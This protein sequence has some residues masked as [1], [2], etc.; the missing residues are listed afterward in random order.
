MIIC[1]EPIERGTKKIVKAHVCK[2]LGF[3][4]GITA[5]VYAGKEEG[6]TLLITSLLHG[7]EWFSVLIIREFLNRLDLDKLKG[8]VI[9]I[10]VANTSAFYTGTRCIMDNSDEPDANRSFNGQYNVL[11][12]A[13]TKKLEEEFLSK[14]D[15]LIDFHVG[16]WGSRM[17]D[18]GYGS[19]YKD[20]AVI[21]KS[22][23]MAKAFCFPVLHA[24]TLFKNTHSPRTSMGC[25]ASK[26][27]IP[28]IVPEIGGLGFGEEIEAGWLEENMKGLFGNLKYLGML[29]GEPEYCEKYLQVGDY[30]RVSPKNGGYLELVV[31]PSD[32]LTK[33]SKGQLLANLIDP[34][35]LEIVEEIRSPGD[36]Y[37]FYGCRNY[38]IRPGGWVFGVANAETAK[39]INP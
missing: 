1:N 22:F 23:G 34:E 25:A 39:W 13:I 16:S 2:D 8:T 15:C 6:P 12:N 19:D 26:Y 10:P 5:H 18:I 30:W 35:T 29:D 31:D 4:I 37:I 9:A 20:E 3:D 32:A 28:G 33:V 38:M 24:M 27:G 17:A 21:E 11:S 14:A 36:G 7:E